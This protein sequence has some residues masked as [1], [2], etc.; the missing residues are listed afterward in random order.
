MT[1]NI[2]VHITS[3][4]I[5]IA[6]TITIVIIA[7]N[8][9]IVIVIRIFPGLKLT[10]WRPWYLL[11]SQSLHCYLRMRSVFPRAQEPA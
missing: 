4:A 10:V 7:V 11:P 1:V 5:I 3:S 2:L 6:V 9:T 8:V